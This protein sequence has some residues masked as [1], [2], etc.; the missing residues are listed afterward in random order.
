MIMDYPHQPPNPQYV[1]GIPLG[2]VSDWGYQSHL[3][4]K[5]VIVSHKDQTISFQSVGFDIQQSSPLSVMSYD[6]FY[7]HYSQEKNLTDYILL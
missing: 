7:Y 1:S 5:K 4:E 2:N 3:Q 6:Y